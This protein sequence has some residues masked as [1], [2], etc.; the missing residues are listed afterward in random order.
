[1]FAAQHGY[2]PET[3]SQAFEAEWY[4]STHNDIME[5]PARPM[6]MLFDDASEEMRQ[7]CIILLRNFI[8]KVD[9]RWAD[10]RPH[11][12]GDKITYT[13]F[14]FFAIMLSHYDNPNGKHADIV[15]ATQEMLQQC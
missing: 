4:N 14:F 1:M 7:V 9:A 13:D 5:K 10:G 2:M 11:A 6:A 8:T 15:T 3:A 12:A